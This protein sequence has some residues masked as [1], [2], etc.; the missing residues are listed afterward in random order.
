MNMPSSRLTKSFDY[1][2]RAKAVIPMATQ[3]LSKGPTQFV[4]GVAPIYLERG[5]G[6]HVFDVDGNEYID[7]PGALGP[8]V[9]GYSY[10]CVDRA[11]RR[12]LRDG[13]VFS[14]MHPLEVEVAEKLVQLIPCAEMVRFAKNGSDVTSAAIRLARAA[15]GREKI[16]KCGY[17]GAQDWNIAST[18]WNLGVPRFNKEL[19]IEFAYNRLD[20]LEDIF[21]K[22]P[23]EIAAVI[24]EPVTSELPNS[25]FL[26]AVKDL[27]HRNGAILIF[28]EVKTGFRV[29]L[30]GAQQHFNVTPDL[31]TFGKALANG[32]P[33]SALVGK[34]VYMKMFEN[35]VFFSMTFGGEALSLAAAKATISEM[36]KRGVHS[37]IWKLGTKLQD[38]FNMLAVELDLKETLQCVGLPSKS[39]VKFNATS[40]VESLTLK[41]LFQQEVIKRGILFNGEHMLT[42]SH[43]EEDIMHTLDAYREAMEIL[44]RAIETNSVDQMIEGTKIQTIFREQ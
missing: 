29:A 20:T 18:S 28:D 7:Y 44:K 25:G 13:I 26:A 15:T 37:Y 10:P 6:S 35:G 4:Q 40:G 17:H 30:G 27:A 31:A 12:Q 43:T 32:M 41:S 42:Y 5:K 19:I 1:L 22:H 21:Q 8:V 2:R 9:L 36:E 14:L 24:M 11:I 3:T 39:V 34:E 16:A 38:Q 23:E 33:V